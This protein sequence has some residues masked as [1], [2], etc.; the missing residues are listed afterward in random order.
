MTRAVKDCTREDIRDAYRIL[1]GK[2][3]VMRLIGETK[4]CMIRC[5]LDSTGFG[6]VRVMGTEFRTVQGN[7]LPDE[8]QL[9]K[10]HSVPECVNC[11]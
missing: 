9:L 10:K 3:E 1:F 6:Y 11:T 8:R 2:P 5:G 4:M 7:Y